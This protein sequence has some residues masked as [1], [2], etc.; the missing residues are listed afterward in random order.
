[1]VV[2][3]YSDD[4]AAGEIILNLYEPNHPGMVPALSVKGLKT[5]ANAQLSQSTGEGL[6]GF[7]VVDYSAKAPG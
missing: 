1:V 6:R 5:S 2:C 7:F 3:G 4:P